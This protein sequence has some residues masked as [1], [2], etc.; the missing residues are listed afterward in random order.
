MAKL[1]ALLVCFFYRPVA[2]GSQPFGETRVGSLPL[3]ITVHKEA[4]TAASF[5]LSWHWIEATMICVLCGRIQTGL[6]K[7]IVLAN[8]F[9]GCR[10]LALF[11]KENEIK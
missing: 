5:S 4:T 2:S 8:Y 10:N 1:L 7:I 11:L 9:D 6:R 3:T